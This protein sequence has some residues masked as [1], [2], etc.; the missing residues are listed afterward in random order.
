MANSDG[1]SQNPLPMMFPQDPKAVTVMGDATTSRAGAQSLEKQLSYSDT[2]SPYIPDLENWDGKSHQDIYTGVQAMKPG[3]IQMYA[4]SWNNIASSL[5]GG[6]F[7]SNL[8]V[9]NALAEGAKGQIANAAADSAQKFF[10]Q[11]TQ[12]QD[13]VTAVAARI[14]S[15]ADGAEAVKLSVPPP[16]NAAA[17]PTPTSPDAAEVGALIGVTAASSVMNSGRSEE[18]LHQT[19]IA[20]MKNNYDPTF[21]PAG[22]GIPTFVSVDKPG[23]STNPNAN[24]GPSNTSPGN[25]KNDNTKDNSQNPN[26]SQQKDPSNSDQSSQQSPSS[27]NQGTSNS[28][29]SPQSADSSSSNP[30]TST[31]TAGYNGGAGGGAGGL[32]GLDSG[33]T[34]GGSGG[35][36]QSIPGTGNGNSAA[37]AASTNGAAKTTSSGTSGMPGMGGAGARKSEDEEREHKTPDYLIMDRE[38]ELIG[39]LDPA[40]G[41]ALGA[42]FPAAQTQ[43]DNGEGNYR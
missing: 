11:M 10:Q 4:T 16:N 34:S 29:T 8:A 14:R 33:T 41:G 15:V 23:G 18:N 22:T 6:L 27:A 26:N 24:T 40:S 25:A 32:G 1:N 9:Q 42:D 21:G 31:G 5:G 2:D 19:A 37:A 35:A 38:E 43:R 17:V 12:L 13:V 36:G 7:G 30:S 3:S 20:A 39:R 28:N